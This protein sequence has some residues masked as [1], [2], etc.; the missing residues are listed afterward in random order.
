M[1]LKAAKTLG[2]KRVWAVFQPFTYSRTEILMDDFVSALSIADRVVL[3]DIMGSREKNLHG[4]YTEQLGEKISGAVWFD[5][6]HEVV[7]KQTAQQKEF[8]FGQV[9][10][11][12]LQN[13]GEGD[14]VIT[15][16]CGDVYK[17][18][19]LLVKKLE[20]KYTQ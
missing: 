10:D 12:I 18:A 6:P 14:L 2:F 1:T 11:F 19:K 16:G 3:T 8:N 7:D 4:I 17:A 13:A 15:M 9:T 20:E 5:T